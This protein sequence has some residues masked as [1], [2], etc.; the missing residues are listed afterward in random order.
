MR[1]RK[2]CTTYLP[3][4]LEKHLRYKRNVHNINMKSPKTKCETSQ[5][6]DN[7]IVGCCKVFHKTSGMVHI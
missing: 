2:L 3:K 7:D 5:V 1:R 6:G 4:G